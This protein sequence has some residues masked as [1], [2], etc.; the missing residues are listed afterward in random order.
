VI[1]KPHPTKREAA[2]AE[3]AVGTV[4]SHWNHL[5]ENLQA[6]PLDF[7]TSVH[8][9][10]DK[11]QIPQVQ[12]SRVEYHEGGVLSARREYLR[13]KRGRHIFDICGAPFGNGFF[14]S[15][16]L[17]EPQSSLGGLALVLVLIGTMIVLLFSTAHFGFFMGLFIAIVAVPLLFLALVA[18]LKEMPEGSDDA[19]VA[20]PWLGPIYERLFRPK[21]YYKIDTALMFQQSVHAAVMEAVD[22]LTS[23]KGLRAL[24]ELERK[25]ILKEFFQR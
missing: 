14:V 21:T 18:A 5:I 19:L 12:I 2:M 24:S 15:W 8:G 23:A 25:P 22:G 16:W 17:G 4:L 13:V 6:S 3:A 20:M 7:Y 11:R 10:V 9:L 1:G